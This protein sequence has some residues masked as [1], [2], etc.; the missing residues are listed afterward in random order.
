MLA[1]TLAFA[2]ACAPRAP[3]GSASASPEPDVVVT[4]SL[5]DADANGGTLIVENASIWEVRVFLVRGGQYVRLGVAR[6]GT[7]SSF[8][9]APQYVNRDLSFYVEAIGAGARQRTES[10]YVRASQE[11]TLKL[12]LRLRSY[13]IVVH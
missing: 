9:V 2:A 12:E 3:G 10:V 11:V 6:S 8:R 5:S 4:D 1:V 7:T 13:S